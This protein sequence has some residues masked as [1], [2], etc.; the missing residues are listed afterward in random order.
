VYVR[1]VVSALSAAG[2]VIVP[3]LIDPQLARTLYTMLLLRRHRGEY[4]RD[5][6]VP[7]ALS[8]WG[9]STLDALLLSV[10]ADVEAAAGC[11]LLPTYCYARLY[12]HGDA[13][14]R[15]RDR[16]A[17]EIAATIH[18]GHRGA[19]PP[20]ICFAPDHA[21]AQRP[22]DGVVYLGT[23]VEHWRDAFTGS[24]FGQVFVNFV[25]A[26][27]AHRHLAF[28]GRHGA[29]PATMAIEPATATAQRP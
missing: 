14:A 19:A 10:Q 6:Q 3:G 2:H 18:L 29:F 1:R 11:A 13:L 5:D 21:V 16:D 25:R 22:G 20:P 12:Q 15:H 7:S 8:F 27:G 9:D 17:A 28:D 4:R 23:K 26:G 24:D